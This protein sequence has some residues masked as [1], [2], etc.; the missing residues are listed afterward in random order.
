SLSAHKTVVSS[1]TYYQD[2]RPLME[3]QCASCHDQRGRAPMLL[4][5]D[6]AV[7]AYPAIERALLQQSRPEHGSQLAHVEFDRVMTW[8]AG[9][10]P[11]GERPPGAPPPAPKRHATH[12]GQLGG[13]L[14]PLAGDTLHAEAVFSEQRRLRVVVT[15]TSG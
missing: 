2:I 9:G 5:Y 10:T 15:T 1:F 13:L 14:V 12:G 8:A 6:D 7:A 4:R 3:K 11:E